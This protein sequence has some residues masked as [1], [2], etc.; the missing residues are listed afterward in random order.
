MLSEYECARELV[1]DNL[2]NEDGVLTVEE[3]AVEKV[4]GERQMSANA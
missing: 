3:S 4:C 1:N 2:C